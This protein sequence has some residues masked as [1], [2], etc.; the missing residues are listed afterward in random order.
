M[1]TSLLKK[2]KKNI[3]FHNNASSG[4]FAEVEKVN[5]QLKRNQSYENK[6]TQS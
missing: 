5:C 3:V 2:V 4:L 1:L 6:L